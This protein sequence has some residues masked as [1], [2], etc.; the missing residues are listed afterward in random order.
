MGDNGFRAVFHDG[1]GARGSPTADDV[2]CCVCSHTYGANNGSTRIRN[3]YETG[4]QRGSRRR[5]SGD[6][7]GHVSF[8]ISHRVHVDTSFGA[9][10]RLVLRENSGACRLSLFIGVHPRTLEVSPRDRGRSNDL[11]SRHRF[12]GIAGQNVRRWASISA[13]SS[14]VAAA[15]GVRRASCSS[16]MRSRSRASVTTAPA[17]R[18]TRSPPR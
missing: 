18:Q 17:S 4:E 8:R 2:C 9:S 11:F 16:T 13:S 6:S 15:T 5:R 7:T 3:R 10:F 14:G 12:P 1:K